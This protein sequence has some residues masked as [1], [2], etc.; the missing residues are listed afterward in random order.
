[1]SI[2]RCLLVNFCFFFQKVNIYVLQFSF[3]NVILL[4]LAWCYQRLIELNVIE[5][6]VMVELVHLLTESAK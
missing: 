1:M 4:M 5:L 2:H 3:R 6:N